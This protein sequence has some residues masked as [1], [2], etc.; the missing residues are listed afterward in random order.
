MK[1]YKDNYIADWIFICLMSWYSISN[2]IRVLTNL[3]TTRLN[4]IIGIS[5]LLLL[6]YRHRVFNVIKRDLFIIG[7]WTVYLLFYYYHT[8]VEQ[9][10]SLNLVKV[11]LPDAKN[12]FLYIFSYL[13]IAIFVFNNA[14]RL[15]SILFKLMLFSIVTSLLL[16]V[17]VFVTQ[18]LSFFFSE[19]LMV[20]NT[21][22]SLITMSYNFVFIAVLSIYLLYNKK[23]KHYKY[24][25]ATCLVISILSILFLGKRGALFSVMIAGLC[26]TL[27]STG[28]LKK[29]LFYL[30]SI[31]LIFAFLYSNFNYVIDFFSLF[32]ERL[33][34][35]V[36][37][38]YN[39]GDTNG[40]DR[41][42]EIAIEQI[43][44]N[45]IYGYYPK[46]I[47][48]SINSWEWGMHPHNIFLESLMTMG[49]VGSV[50]LFVYM[51]YIL[52][53]KVYPSLKTYN[54]NCP[55]RFFAILFIAE[56]VHGCFSGTLHSSWIWPC[57][58]VLAANKSYR[59]IKSLL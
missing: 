42:W 57:M 49:I 21:G 58:F 29:F 2:I 6:L 45:P 15:N 19:G 50:P 51:F 26:L 11:T 40:R 20:A 27:L 14:Y 9:V 53:T 12:L 18:G 59:S 38:A 55:Y 39:F 3:N 32:S 17:L 48:C 25:E 46:L 5:F 1:R 54:E 36:D 30:L 24:I 28:S 33:A 37:L 13:G 23:D 10:V 8:E 44:K 31:I 16:L 35:Q 56:L 52:I 41:I 47:L 43:N 7:L 34:Y 4:H 22:F